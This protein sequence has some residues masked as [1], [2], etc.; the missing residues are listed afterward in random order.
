M[1]SET[2]YVQRAY[3]VRCWR[4][5]EAASEGEAAWRFS[6]EVVTPG[7]RRRGFA[8]LEALLAFVQ[9]DLAGGDEDRPPGASPDA[10]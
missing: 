4:D 10:S 9:D 5:R 3:L 1:Q 6:V 2:G 7:R 8:S